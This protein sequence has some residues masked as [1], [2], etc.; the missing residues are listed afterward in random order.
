MRL[1]FLS[2]ALS[3]LLLLPAAAQ[4]DTFNFN[5]IGSG[6]GFSGSGVLTASNNGD[7]SYTI[8]AMS[9]SGITGLIAADGFFGNDNLLFPTASRLLDVNGFAFTQVL[10]GVTYSVNIFSTVAGYEAIS[11]GSDGDFED[12]P[13]TFTLTNTSAVAPEP[14]SLFLLGS[15]ILAAAAT[16]IRRRL[17]V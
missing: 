14:S 2:L 7:G 5:A 13:V 1:S 6:G 12:A 17:N 10:A 9:G 16:Q 3:G 11:L 8:N 15:G 4:A